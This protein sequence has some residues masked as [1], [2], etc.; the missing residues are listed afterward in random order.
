MA[1]N[2][3]LMLTGWLAVNIR[4]APL[5]SAL[6]L[7]ILPARDVIRMDVGV[8]GTFEMISASA[9]MSKRGVQPRWTRSQLI[10]ATTTMTMIQFSPSLLL[11][12]ANSVQPVWTKLLTGEKC[13]ILYFFSYHGASRKHATKFTL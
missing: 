13:E 10:T 5:E 3:R 12:Q 1:C 8:K 9:E 2:V 6:G 7:A 11:L 4:F